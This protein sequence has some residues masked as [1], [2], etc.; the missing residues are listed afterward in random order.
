MKM[1]K[2]LKT[3][4]KVESG[5]LKLIEPMD[6]AYI[7]S[8]KKMTGSGFKKGDEVFV[9][10]SKWL[11]E[12]K[13]D[14][15]LIRCYLIVVK[16]DE[17]KVPLIPKDAEDPNFAWLV[18]PRNLE[19]FDKD[20]QSAYEAAL[21]KDGIDGDILLHELGW[22]GQ[23]KDNETGE[24][25]LLSWDHV[26]DLLQA[27]IEEICLEVGATEP[28]TFFITDSQWIADVENRACKWNGEHPREFQE[29][30]RY[31]LAISKPYKGTR[32]NPKP[33]YFY[34]ILHDLLFN[35]DCVVSKGGLEADDELGI[36]QCS[37]EQG[38]TIICSRDKDLRIIPGWHYSWECGAQGS[39]GPTYTDRVGWLEKRQ[40][41]DVLGFG[42]SFF[43]YQMLVGDSA[44]NI[45]GLPKWGKVKA[46]NLLKDLKTE[47]ELFEAVKAAYKE[48]MGSE[49]KEYFFEQANLLWIRQE[50]DYGYEIPN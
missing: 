28:P 32:K 1:K 17:D 8:A 36:A 29:G 20:K 40:T 9:V 46:Y 10:G 33:L 35:R 44:D 43:Y 26:Y 27:K 16:L 4:E 18:D 42:L 47:K 30:F 19:P 21:N 34:A 11:P 31:A 37:D 23:F 45:P 6:F 49:S 12:K 3:A 25:I 24:D 48:T 15:Y 14:P 2:K 41:G 7:V 22:S 13:H 38:R 5:K 50:R 39:I